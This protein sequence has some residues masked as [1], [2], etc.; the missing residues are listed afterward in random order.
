MEKEHLL[1]CSFEI[2]GRFCKIRLKNVEIG[3]I[4]ETVSH[5]ER[6]YG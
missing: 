3:G 1:G 4:I 5:K 6:G 2:V